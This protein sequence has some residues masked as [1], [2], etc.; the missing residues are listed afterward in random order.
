MAWVMQWM[1]KIGGVDN[2]VSLKMSFLFMVV[3]AAIFSSAVSAAAAE[4]GANGKVVQ[5]SQVSAYPFDSTVLVSVSLKAAGKL[6]DARLTVS[7][8]ELNIMAGHR[9]GFSRDSRQTVRLELP[10]PEEF[11]P[12]MRIAFNSDEGR[13]V[14]YRPVILQ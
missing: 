11:D 4:A 2:M 9:V 7:I 12:Y 6:S 3:L 1:F 8:P 14:K 5:I 10:I 13:R